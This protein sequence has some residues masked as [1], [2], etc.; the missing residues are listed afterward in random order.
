MAER[1]VYD[2]PSQPDHRPTCT[3]LQ[4]RRHIYKQTDTS[5]AAVFDTLYF[6]VIQLKYNGIILLDIIFHF[7]LKTTTH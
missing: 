5:Q 1:P 6:K 3:K 2:P 7:H 4:L